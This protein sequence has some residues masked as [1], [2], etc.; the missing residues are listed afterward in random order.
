[1]YNVFYMR[2]PSH[3]PSVA[4]SV[5][6]LRRVRIIEVLIYNIL[7]F[8]LISS[9]S[10]TSI[11]LIKFSQTFLYPE[12]QV[13]TKPDARL[14]SNLNLGL[15]SVI[16]HQSFG[17]CHQCNRTN[18]TTEHLD[19]NIVLNFLIFTFLDKIAKREIILNLISESIPLIT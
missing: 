12:F 13:L 7:H 1:M 8:P 11:P 9:F 2:R 14:A 10:D 16:S 15:C 19:T 3:P 18:F 5:N 6:M 4:S 17:D